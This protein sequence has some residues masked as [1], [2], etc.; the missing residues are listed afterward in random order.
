MLFRSSSAPQI[1]AGKL[2]ALAMAS[3]KR[4]PAFPDTPTAA[5][6]G[7]SGFEVSTWYALFA[8][9]SASPEIVA[10]MTEE[11]K[12]AFRTPVIIDAWG[13]NGSEIPSLFGAEFGKFVNAEIARWGKVVK[14]A[15]VRLD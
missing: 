9:R 1:A 4:S 6:A 2:R 8:H 12:T 5:E 3:A 7:V 10:R 11:L 15:N 14:D 13:K